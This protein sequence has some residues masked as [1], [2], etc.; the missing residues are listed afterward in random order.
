MN[1]FSHIDE[2]GRVRMVDVS[3]KSTI[4]RRAVATGKVVMSEGTFKKITSKSV[5][6]GNVLETSR[7]AA[8]IGAKKT[9]DLIPMCHPL[10]L[11]H[12]KVEFT[13]EKDIPAILIQEE[14]AI[15]DFF[16]A[17]KY[18]RPVCLRN[19]IRP[20]FFRNLS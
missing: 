16:P 1:E 13:P 20:G 14:V 10:N 19:W 6:K 3:E 7:I 12:V 11:A 18:N 4:K 5:A 9:A 2:K 17:S 8:I 15:N